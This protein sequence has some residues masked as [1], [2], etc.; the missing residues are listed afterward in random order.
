MTEIGEIGDGEIGDRHG[1]C[2]S[3]RPEQPRRKP[4][5]LKSLISQR[6]PRFGPADPRRTGAVTCL[7]PI[8]V[9]DL[10]VTDLWSPI[11]GIGMSPGA[12]DLITA[13]SAGSIRFVAPQH[14]HDSD[15]PVL[16]VDFVQHAV[17]ADADAPCR[18]ERLQLPASSRSRVLGQRE[19][20]GMRLDRKRRPPTRRDPS[21]QSA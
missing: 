6:L 1:T 9:T 14:T 7:S 20:L 5:P 19:D 16:V 2:G 4:E 8:S 21:E 11:S 10:F 13:G 17:V 12:S 15:F 18:L 3:A